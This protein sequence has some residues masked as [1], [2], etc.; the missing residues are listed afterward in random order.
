M[1]KAVVSTSV[2]AEGLDVHQGQDII[3]ADQPSGFAESVLMLLRNTE[4]RQRYESAA[5]NLA[6]QYDWS[7]ASAKFAHA[8]SSAINAD[9]LE[10]RS[11][12]L[13]RADS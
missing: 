6:A 10:A 12:A 2:G 1:A 3:L 9:H 11:T 8:L 4:L 7:A 13:L 5:T